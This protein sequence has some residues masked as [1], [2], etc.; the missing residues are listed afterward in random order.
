ML[1]SMSAHLLR[2]ENWTCDAIILLQQDLNVVRLAISNCLNKKTTNNKVHTILKIEHGNK[3]RPE[4]LLSINSNRVS[5]LTW[6][7]W[8]VVPLPKDAY[9]K[10]N[11][12]LIGSKLGGQHFRKQHLSNTWLEHEQYIIIRILKCCFVSWF[13]HKCSRR[14]ARQKREARDTYHAR[15]SCSGV[16]PARSGMRWS[17]FFS[18]I[19]YFKFYRKGCIPSSVKH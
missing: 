9:V 5:Y 7:K 19:R 8:M 17:H 4:A 6:S 10:L 15:T 18:S 12:P 1:S 11:P 14:R 13:R 2:V 3:W 16:T